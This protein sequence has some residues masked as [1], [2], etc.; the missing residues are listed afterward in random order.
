MQKGTY[1]AAYQGRPGA[2]SEGAARQVFSRH[3]ILLPC[4]R[5]EDVFFAVR[6]SVVWYGVIPIENSLGGSI[7][8][9]YDLLRKHR[10]LIVGETICRIQHAL[11]AAKGVKLREVKKVLSHPMALLQCQRFF[12]KHPGIKPIPEFDTAGAV[13][14]VINENLRDTAAIAGKRNG[15]IYGGVVLED[16]IQDRANNSTRFLLIA[17]KPAELSP[18][19]KTKTTILFKLRNEPGALFRALKPFAERKINWTKT[20]SRPLGTSRRKYPFE[21]RFF[22]DIVSSRPDR[23]KEVAAAIEDL[24]EIDPSLRVLGTYPC[25]I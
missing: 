23:G 14:K 24:R 15:D 16:K 2:F 3:S 1:F 22:A 9:S 19:E 12:Q 17:R 18:T 8:L 4:D 11:I 25:S 5:L 21:Y 13:E 6:H 10:L 7:Y 20:E